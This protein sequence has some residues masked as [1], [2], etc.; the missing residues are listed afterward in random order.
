MKTKMVATEYRLSQWA[1][2]LQEKASK[3]ESIDEFCQ[4]RGISRNRYFYWQRKLREKA[5]ETLVELAG[6][7]QTKL[8]PSGFAEVKL[9]ADAKHK[10]VCADESQGMLLVEVAGLRINVDGAYPADK[11]AYILRELVRSC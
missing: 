1:Q 11:I 3:C 2:A 10:K 5:C 9:I 8:I 4:R 6:T 7:P